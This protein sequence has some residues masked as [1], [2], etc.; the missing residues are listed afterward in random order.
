MGAGT[1]LGLA[2]CHRIVTQLG[3]RIEA[4]SHPS[5][6]DEGAYRTTFRVTLQS[7]SAATR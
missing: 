2:I 7:A 3:G 6:E 1:G 4:E 5:V